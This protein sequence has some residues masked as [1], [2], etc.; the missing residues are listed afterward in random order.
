ML[1]YWWEP[2]E[3]LQIAFWSMSGFNLLLIVIVVIFCIL[4]RNAKR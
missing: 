3:P 2:K 4:W 1:Q